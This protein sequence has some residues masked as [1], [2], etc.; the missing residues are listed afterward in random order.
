MNKR[1]LAKLTKLRT[2]IEAAKL[3]A[4]KVRDELRELLSDVEEVASDF[5]DG[6][7]SLNSAIDGIDEA[8]TVM[9]RNV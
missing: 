5:D 6:V 9:S 1:D 3:K 8:V 4:G 2:R 7:E